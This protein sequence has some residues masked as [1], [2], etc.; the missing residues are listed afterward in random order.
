VVRSRRLP[1]LAATAVLLLAACASPPAA[2]APSAA[3]SATTTAVP[4]PTCDADAVLASWSLH[5][6]ARQT[7]IVPVN[8]T[9]VGSVSA[10]VADG[11]GGVILFGSAA[12]ANLGTA[13]ATL[14][15][16]APDGIEPFI[17][18]DEEGGAV[19]RMP[20]L[21]GDL[22]SARTMAA[23]MTPEEIRA[24]AQEVGA[25]MR[26][27]GVTMNLAPVLDLDDRPGPNASNP[28]GSRSFSRDRRIAEAAGVAFAQGMMASGVIPVV[29]HFPGLGGA[30]GNTDNVAATTRPWS[31]LQ[32]DDLLPFVA[33][34]AAGVPAVMVANASVPGL[35][36]RPASVSPE[37]ITGVLRQRLR[38]DGLIMTDALSGGAIDSAGF[39]VPTAAVAALSAGADM[40]MFTAIDVAGTTRETVEAIVAAVQAGT[41]TRARL[42]DA[43]RHILEVKDVDLCRAP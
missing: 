32:D 41:L 36:T 18:T 14:V 20:N 31:A 4:S 5:R 43:V 38:F 35:T 21:V 25:A 6:L 27:N 17:M 2:Q 40:V 15:G 30:T 7:V 39:T 11:A 28:D 10:L 23:T 33:A 3:P 37:V 1:A 9:R 24:L 8:Q 19:Q 13:L 16:R 26:D 42:E 22:P 34:F 12:P 29:K